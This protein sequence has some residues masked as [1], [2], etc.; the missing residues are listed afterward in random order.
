MGKEKIWHQPTE[1]PV[2]I[3]FLA[4]TTGEV[5]LEED[6]AGEEEPLGV[7]SDVA[8]RFLISI[9]ALADFDS[10]DMDGPGSIVGTEVDKVGCP[11]RTI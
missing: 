7:S 1:D 3:L 10:T 9:S 8:G 5:I 11:P 2:R 4:G 6:V